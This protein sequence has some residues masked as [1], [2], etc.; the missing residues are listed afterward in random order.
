MSIVVLVT[1]QVLN[2][3]GGNRYW[4]AIKRGIKNVAFCRRV[5]GVSAMS[6]GHLRKVGLLRQDGQTCPLIMC[7]GGGG[8]G[9]GYCSFVYYWSRGMSLAVGEV[10]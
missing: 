4:T 2:S 7:G 5:K 6:R 1:P 10:R 3:W 9:G 8:G